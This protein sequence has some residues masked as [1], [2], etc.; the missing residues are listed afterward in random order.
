MPFG[1]IAGA[2]GGAAVNF[3]LSKLFGGDDKPEFTERERGRSI[4]PVSMLRDPLGTAGDVSTPLPDFSDRFSDLGSLDFSNRLSDFGPLD[5]SDRFSDFGSL[6]VSGSFTTPRGFSAGGLNVAFGDDG[7]TTAE[8]DPGFFREL[9]NAQG[10]ASNFL[11]AQAERFRTNEVTNARLAEL[12]S[13]RA[14]A[15]SNLSENFGRSRVLGSSFAQR[16]IA[17]EERS[18]A[19]QRATIRAEGILQEIDF[20]T[21]FR[22]EADRLLLDRISFEL[23]TVIGDANI[24]SQFGVEIGKIV[25]GNQRIALQAMSNDLISRRS[26]GSQNERALIDAAL[27]DLASRR[28]ETGA[29]ERASI[30]AAMKDLAIRRSTASQNERALIDAAMRDLDSRRRATGAESASVRNALINRGTTGLGFAELGAKESNRTTEARGRLIEP[31]VDAFGT[32]ITSAFQGIGD[33]I[34]SFSTDNS[35]TGGGV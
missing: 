17:A 11:R 19:Q 1:A 9:R 2:I 15:L 12:D 10:Q 14:R 26:T 6:D 20:E 3:G 21:R 22:Q 13:A 33:N 34:G 31:I 16:A 23:N 7:F 4:V 8:R 5:L 24:A 28:S 27:R 35:F 25:A 29:N 30:D 32:S 18:F